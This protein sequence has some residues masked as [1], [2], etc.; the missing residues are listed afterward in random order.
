MMPAAKPRSKGPV[1]V[2]Q[3]GDRF[4]NFVLEEI[5]TGVTLPEDVFERDDG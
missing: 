5:E 1:D 2:Q 4:I 3:A